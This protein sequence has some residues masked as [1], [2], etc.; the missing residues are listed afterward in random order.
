MERRRQGTPHL[1]AR[2]ARRSSSSRRPI[3]GSGGMACTSCV[4]LMGAVL[5]NAVSEKKS[6]FSVITS[7]LSMLRASC[8]CSHS[9]E[10]ALENTGV[11]P[12]P[13]HGRAP[14]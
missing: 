14:L 12:D 10:A 9:G 5:P 11:W 8:T 6:I 7:A 2:E 3:V 1:I 13:N 4:C